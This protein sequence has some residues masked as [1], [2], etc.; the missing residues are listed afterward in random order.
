MF[1][2]HYD[3]QTSF[4]AKFPQMKVMFRDVYDNDKSKQKLDSSNVMW[5]C[6]FLVDRKSMYYP[7]P[8]EDK[9]VLVEEELTGIKGYFTKHKDKCDSILERMVKLVDDTPAKRHLRMWEDLLEKRTKFLSSLDYAPETWKMIDDMASSSKKIFDE[10]E[11]I[12]DM[13]IVEEATAVGEGGV[14]PSMLDED[15]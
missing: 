2:E 8:M 10:L 14:M 13:L 11:K 9:V 3:V 12:K 6:A 1:V 15:I 7:L 4:W 5:A